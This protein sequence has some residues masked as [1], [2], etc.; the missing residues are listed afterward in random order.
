[1]PFRYRGNFQ[2][3][4]S[5]K[6]RSLVS[7]VAAHE[8]EDCN[9][10]GPTPFSH[11]YSPLRLCRERRPIVWASSSR[12]HANATVASNCSLGIRAIATTPTQTTTGTGMR[13]RS[14]TYPALSFPLGGS[15]KLVLQAKAGVPLKMHQC[16]CLGRC[17][18]YGVDPCSE[19]R[20]WPTVVKP[21][22][23]SFGETSCD[24]ERKDGPNDVRRGSVL[25]SRVSRGGS[26]LAEASAVLWQQRWTGS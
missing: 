7:S 1:M 2:A 16:V 19:R 21:T 22:S 13:I 6:R 24:Y 12:L 11:V 9:G 17:S 25:I 23:F 5:P 8:F 4:P 15:W 14:A 10:T 3:A 20:S 26:F 18:S